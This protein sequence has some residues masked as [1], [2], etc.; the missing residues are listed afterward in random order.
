MRFSEPCASPFTCPHSV[1]VPQNSLG[2]WSNARLISVALPK[3]VSFKKCYIT[4]Q[5]SHD[6]AQLPSNRA[7]WQA[8]SK[9][10]HPSHPQPRILP[11][12]SF[13]PNSVWQSRSKQQAASRTPQNRSNTASPAPAQQSQTNQPQTKPAQQPGNFWAQRTSQS[14]EPSNGR[15]AIESAAPAPATFNV[16][17]VR[18]FLARDA[19]AGYTTYKVQEAQ[20]AAKSGSGGAWGAG[21]GE[22]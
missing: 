18:A 12:T 20:G 9:S 6:Q 14:R 7:S 17:E 2:L 8:N 10:K 19:H 5:L 15:T 13:A 22:S 3:H 1:N 4:Q 16:A 11:L 21:K